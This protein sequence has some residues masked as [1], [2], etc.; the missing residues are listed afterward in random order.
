MSVGFRPPD[1]PPSPPKVEILWVVRKGDRE[2]R[3]IVRQHPLGRELVVFVGEDIGWSRLF[4]HHED[5]RTLGEMAE[6]CRLDFERCGW[7]I[8]SST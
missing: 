3:A 6:G 1:P 4:R 2:A 8:D 5:S 7:R